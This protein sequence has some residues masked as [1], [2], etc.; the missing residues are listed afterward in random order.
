MDSQTPVCFALVHHRLA[1]ILGTARKTA[2]PVHR[3]VVKYI[4]SYSFGRIVA[5]DSLEAFQNLLR[6]RTLDSS[7]A[8][9]MKLGPDT[10]VADNR[11]TP[12]ALGI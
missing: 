1:G 7:L 4:P 9:R 10:A 12:V 5:A 6:I 11:E 2:D 8:D 3:R